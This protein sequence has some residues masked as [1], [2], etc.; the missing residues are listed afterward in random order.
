LISGPRPESARA[1]EGKR[2]KRLREREG[3]IE[4]ERGRASDVT[5]GQPAMRR[6]ILGPLGDR[7]GERR[8]VVEEGG[9]RALLQGE[10]GLAREGSSG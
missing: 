4:R 3:E 1:G 2:G 9:E 8:N 6:N 10:K 7:D 5:E